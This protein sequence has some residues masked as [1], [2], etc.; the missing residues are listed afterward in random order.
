[1]H[2]TIRLSFDGVHIDDVARLDKAV[3]LI[4]N[5]VRE[6]QESPDLDLSR[7]L[8]ILS[9]IEIEARSVRKILLESI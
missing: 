8:E 1:M 9:E 6:L 5:S 4:N 3:G 2:S 7:V